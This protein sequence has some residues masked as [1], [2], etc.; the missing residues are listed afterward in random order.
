MSFTLAE[1]KAAD[2]ADPLR[3]Y[4][5]RFDLP[6]GIVGDAQKQGACSFERLGAI[7]RGDRARLGKR[8]LDPLRE[9]DRPLLPA[10]A[11]AQLQPAAP[12]LQAQ[13]LRTRTCPEDD[14]RAER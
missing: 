3:G 10:G 5:D 6:E 13:I 8:A 9:L 12:E 14:Q 2:A 4:R 1:A 11:K 7:R